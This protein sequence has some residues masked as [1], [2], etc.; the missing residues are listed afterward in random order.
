M[1]KRKFPHDALPRIHGSF[2]FANVRQTVDEDSREEV[3][4]SS[5]SRGAEI[6][7]TTRRYLESIGANVKD[8]ASTTATD[9]VSEKTDPTNNSITVLATLRRDAPLLTQAT[10]G[11]LS[12]AVSAA[13][14]ATSRQR[15]LDVYLRDKHA[16]SAY[17]PQES[18]ENTWRKLHKAWFGEGSEPFPTC[19]AAVRAIAA[20][21]KFAKYRSFDNYAS[22]AKRAHIEAGGIWTQEL[23]LEVRDASRS[24]NRGKGPGRQS[25]PL[26]LD[27]IFELD[28][29]EFRNSDSGPVD[30]VRMI[31]MICF[32]VLRE[33]EA[34]FALVK[35]WSLD[36]DKKVITW[37]LPVSK[38]DPT[39]VGCYRSWG[40]VCITPTDNPLECPWHTASAY[41]DSLKRRFAN[42]NESINP[43]MALFPNAH[44]QVLSKD[45]VVLAIERLAEHTGETLVKENGLRR[46]GGHT[47]RVTGSRHWASMGLDMLKIQV[48]ARWGSAV[49]LR[50]VAEAPLQSITTDIKKRMSVHKVWDAISELDKTLSELR[51]QYSEEG[52]VQSRPS[53][54]SGEPPERKPSWVI[55]PKSGVW[56][57]PYAFGTKFHPTVWRTRCGWVFGGAAFDITDE[58][59]TNQKVCDKCV[60]N[61][62]RGPSRNSVEDS[63]SSESEQTG[64]RGSART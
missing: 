61:S 49:I 32:F 19:V 16:R 43:D 38:T 28:P 59:P 5:S 36:F 26:Q 18:L 40:C 42:D 7:D 31:L 17:A 63:S 46:F 45:E 8:D 11:S 41:W 14:D 23:E 9:R 3:A 2:W 52:S 53:E 12:L 13:A 51:A 62:A 44:G 35:H 57:V 56:H 29:E 47:P 22:R 30:P 60:P 33:I 64:T 48:L 25:E 10:R 21:M 6:S 34:A 15:V 1:P 4:G 39:A 58:Q 27:R 55:N 37:H 20:S 24:V 50:Y 54:K